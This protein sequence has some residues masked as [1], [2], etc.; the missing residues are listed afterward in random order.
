VYK[1]EGVMR[2]F[3]IFDM[4]DL[5]SLPVINFHKFSLIEP[6]SEYKGQ[7]RPDGIFAFYYCRVVDSFSLQYYSYSTSALSSGK[8]DLILTPGLGFD[9]NGGRL[10][11]GKGYGCISQRS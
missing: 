5:K 9:D 7:P 8:I 10:G 11:R 4:D 6:T 3:R 2:M 1:D